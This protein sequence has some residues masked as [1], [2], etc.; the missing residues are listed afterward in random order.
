MGPRGGF[1]AHECDG[2]KRTWLQSGYALMT[3]LM[4]RTSSDFVKLLWQRLGAGV[5]TTEDSIRF[6]FFAALLQNGVRPEQVVLE[7]PHPVMRGARVDAVILDAQGEPGS[8]VEFKYDR[9]TPGGSNQPKPQKAGS[10]FADLAR[11]LRFAPLASRSLV[12]VTDK[13][14]ARYLA[15]PANGLA[16][17]FQLRDGDSVQVGPDFF[18]GRSQTFLR[19]MGQWP[20]AA[21]LWSVACC[22]MPREHYLRIYHVEQR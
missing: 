13:E 19:S 15:A 16:S 14:I 18:I 10:V 4:R 12:Y 6:T 22:E 5:Y 11:L 1:L 3:E 2:G 7:F 20:R 21:M 8:A 17:V 9:T